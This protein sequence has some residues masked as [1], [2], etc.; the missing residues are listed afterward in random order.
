[1]HT[2][3]CENHWQMGGLSSYHIGGV[4][5]SRWE[6]RESSNYFDLVM[7]QTCL[8][9]A[10]QVIVG[11]SGKWWNTVWGMKWEQWWDP[12]QAN[13]MLSK[14][15]CDHPMTSTHQCDNVMSRIWRP[16]DKTVR[17]NNTHESLTRSHLGH[18]S[19][20]NTNIAAWCMMHTEYPCLHVD[21]LLPLGKM[22]Q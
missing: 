4:I 22:L 7:E 6:R 12:P 1:M 8:V 5:I 9:C 19:V 21:H 10:P 11:C 3:Q 20:W 14:A 2:L 15:H 17:M 16:W 18:L 13:C